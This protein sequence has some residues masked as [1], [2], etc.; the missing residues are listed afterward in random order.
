MKFRTK[1]AAL[2]H[3]SQLDAEM[4]EEMRLHIEL[5][6]KLNRQAGMPAED[7]RH[8]ALRQFGNVA[9]I[10]EDCREQRGWLWLE[11]VWQDMAYAGRQM[12]KAPSFAATVIVTLGLG[13]GACAVVF[14]AINATLV[15]PLAGQRTNREVIFHETQPPQRPQMAL[16]AGSYL[17]LVKVAKSFDILG[18]WTG[19]PILIEGG[20]EP[21]Q[22]R[23]A[24]LTPGVMHGWNNMTILGREFLPEE[25]KGGL[26]VVMISH[27]LWLRLFG[28]DPGVLNRPLT[29]EGTLCTIVGVISPRFALYGSDIE[30]WLPMD[31]SGMQVPNRNVRYLQT[32]A[33]LKPGVTLAQAQAE[34]D[35]LAANLARQYPDT[36]K[37]VGF[38]VRDLG[39][40]I[41]RSLAP[42]LYILLGVVGCVLLIACANV[43]NLLLARGMTRQREISVRAALG[44]SRGRIMRQ[45]LVES[46]L[47][48]GLGGA[49]GIVLAHWGLRFIR[50]YGPAAG[51]DLAR[52]AYVELDSSVLVF[53]VGFSLAVGLFFGLAPAWLGSRVDLHDAMKQGSRGNSEAGA[54]SRLRRLLMIMEISLALLLLTG[55]GLLTR[56]FIKRAQI[57]PGFEPRQIATASVGLSSRRYRDTAQRRQMTDAV[58]E[59]VRAL[60]GVERAAV[61]HIGPYN[62]A[63]PLAFDLAGRP[64]DGVPRTAVPLLVTAEYF[65]TMRIRLLRGRTFTAQDGVSGPPVFVVNEAF[66]RQYFGDENPLGH[67]IALNLQGER[68]NDRTSAERPPGTSGEI[69]GV[70]ADVMQGAPGVP[71]QPQMYLTWAS[72]NTNGF[73]LM[74]RTR[75]DP[76]TFLTSIK[77]QIFE[78]DRQQPV[79]WARP[80]EDVMGDSQARS[81]LMLMLLVT[82]GMI[83]LVIAAVGIYSVMAYSV[84]QRTM[85]FGIRMALGASR[86]DIL[87][88]VLRGGMKTVALGLAVGLAAALVCGQILQAMLY[89][90]HPRDPVT[91]AAVVGLLAQVA[92]VACWLPARRATKVDPIIALRAE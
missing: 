70:V 1:L 16:S 42:M 90:T 82:F 75:G 49:L 6:A 64:A 21:V 24:R 34:M 51:T 83:A 71:A 53:M 25:F 10:Q 15:H 68:V 81:Q 47:L 41:N 56:G 43:A 76:S 46:L 69:V 39:T 23:G 8:A 91:L 44:A 87:R 35:V 28:G 33:R 3:R 12:A 78:V 22:V 20:A 80:L 54:R 86:G 52:L 62:N 11:Q 79:Q 84:S 40:Y 55:A 60:P 4:T 9:S 65:E 7:A 85:E 73:L 29:V 19:A 72:S 48:A 59:R 57:D 31:L 18:A 5:Q 26:R 74:V 45:F 14:T 61:A 50:I 38:L 17:D 2:F 92:F 58:L 88:Q 32:T 63:G 13:I 66:V 27:A 89:D 67:R 36:N 37:G 77:Q 30:I